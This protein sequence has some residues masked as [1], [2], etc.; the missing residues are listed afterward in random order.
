MF[1]YFRVLEGYEFDPDDNGETFRSPGGQVSVTI[2]DREG[3]LD[4]TV[5]AHEWGHYL[6][7]REVIGARPG[8]HGYATM[9]ALL[10]DKHTLFIADIGRASTN[11]TPRA[12]SDV[13]AAGRSATT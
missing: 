2:T 3:A 13:N 10:L 8:S 7:L 9:N 6:H 12:D 4:N 5:T 11:R 1:D